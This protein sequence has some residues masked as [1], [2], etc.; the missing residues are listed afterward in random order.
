MW[1]K[2]NR[3]TQATLTVRVAAYTGL[4]LTGPGAAEVGRRVAESGERFWA[5]LTTDNEARES[6]AERV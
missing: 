2:R 3:R 4:R 1:G 6:T 5:S